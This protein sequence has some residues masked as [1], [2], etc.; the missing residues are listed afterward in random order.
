M[1]TF[2]SRLSIGWC[3]TFHPEP[4]WPAHGH[5]HCPACFR[6][7]PVPWQEGDEFARR[8]LSASAHGSKPRFSVLQFQKNRG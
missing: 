3:R 5:Y 2:W 6:V 1:R 4:S 8:T 7:Y